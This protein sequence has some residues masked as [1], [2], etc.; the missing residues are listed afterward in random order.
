MNDIFKLGPKQFSSRLLLG[1][2]KFSSAKIMADS[3]QAS[4]AEIVTVAMRRVDLKDPEDQFLT[5]LNRGLNTGSNNSELTFMPNTSGARNA[6]EALKI[7]HLARAATGSNWIKVE[8]HPDAKY[9]LPDPIETLKASE[10][11]V[12]EGF[13]VLPYINAD[14]VLAKR[15]EEIGVAAVMPLAAPIGSN[16]GLTVRSMLEII[17]EQARVPVIVDAGLGRPSHAADCMELG[18]DAVLVNTAIAV[19]HDAVLMAGAFKQAVQAGRD[20]F[21]AGLGQEVLGQAV[22]TSKIDSELT[23]FLG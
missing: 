14:P 7:A 10:I 5:E 9:L 18:A 11:L 8:I 12:R 20:G 1:T 19:A 17:I 23:G 3:I 22:A 13:V 15:L 4:G 2:G 6:E 21:L 16:R